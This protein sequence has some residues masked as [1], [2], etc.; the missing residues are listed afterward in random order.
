MA[1]AETVKVLH[2]GKAALR[3][4]RQAAPLEEK[5]LDLWRA[6]HLYVQIVGMRRQ[7]MPWEQPWN[8][9]SDLRE[10][11]TVR[12]GELVEIDPARHPTTASRSRWVRL[13]SALQI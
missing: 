6:Q 12:N 3:R 2:E 5:I 4:N 1:F 7:L 8:I 9:M 13:R 11:I 10:S